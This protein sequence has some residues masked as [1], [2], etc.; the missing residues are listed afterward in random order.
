MT[1]APDLEIYRAVSRVQE[2]CEAMVRAHGDGTAYIVT[3]EDG[4]AETLGEVIARGRVALNDLAKMFGRPE[5]A[6][7]DGR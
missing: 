4:T 7:D 1:T 5:E 3:F 6:T 2:T